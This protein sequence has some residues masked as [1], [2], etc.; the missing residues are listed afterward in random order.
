M[1]P[2]VYHLSLYCSCI[3]FSNDLHT[4]VNKTQ[5]VRENKLES[6]VL[7]ALFAVCQHMSAGQHAAPRPASMSISCVARELRGRSG[8]GDRSPSALAAPGI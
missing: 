3:L 8:Q 2:S 5:R 1:I 4:S 7:H 6:C